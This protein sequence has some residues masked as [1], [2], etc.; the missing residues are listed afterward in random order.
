MLMLQKSSARI[1]VQEHTLLVAVS[2]SRLNVV[3]TVGKLKA[4]ISDII[5]VKADIL[6]DCVGHVV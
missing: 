3:P 2:A 1:L 5:K 6:A 4:A